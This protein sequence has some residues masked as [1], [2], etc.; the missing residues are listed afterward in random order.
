M[1]ATLD[2]SCTL[3]GDPATGYRNTATAG[4]AVSGAHW[5]ARCEAH[6]PYEHKPPGGW[7][8]RSS[9]PKPLRPGDGVELLPGAPI[10]PTVGVCAGARG[11]VLRTSLEP[12]SRA[13]GVSWVTVRFDRWGALVRIPR[14]YLQHHTTP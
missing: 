13:G 6:N 4:A 12:G 11:Q 10:R 5:E 14:A 7:P 8:D 9:E 2:K 3:C 1:T